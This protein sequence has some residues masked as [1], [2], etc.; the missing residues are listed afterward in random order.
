LTA[1][2]IQTTEG[3]KEWTGNYGTMIDFQVAVSSTDGPQTVVITQ[4]PTSTPP[5]IGDVIEGTVTKNQ[6]GLK[7]KR[8]FDGGGSLNEVAPSSN[9]SASVGKA[10]GPRDDAVRRAVAFKGAIEVAVKADGGASVENVRALT[11][12]FDDVLKV[13]A[14]AP[15]A[16][17]AELFAEPSGEDLVKEVAF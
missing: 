11:D 5:A 8:A 2:T 13:P 14:P 3:Q 16:P 17:E 10:F 7:L 4:K 9:G 1:Y 12:A 15:P 6:Y